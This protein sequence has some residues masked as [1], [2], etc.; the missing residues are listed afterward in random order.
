MPIPVFAPGFRLSLLD[1]A[2]LLL[3]SIA[4]VA[5]G[6]MTWW[7]GF[8]V[9]FVLAHFLLFCN[10]FRIARSLELVWAGVFTALAGGTIAAEKPGWIITAAASFAVTIIVVVLEM[11]KPS[12]HGIGWSRINPKLPSWWEGNSTQLHRES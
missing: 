11:R 2:V 8:V 12:Y 9:G 7:W 10:V 4:V 3:G 1:V 5:L 6:N